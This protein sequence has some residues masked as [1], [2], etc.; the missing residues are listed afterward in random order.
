MKEVEI[1]AGHDPDKYTVERLKAKSHDGRLVPIS[2]IRLK[3]LN[4]MEKIKCC[5]MLM[6]LTNI[7]FLL[8]LVPQGF[9]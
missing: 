6:E 2:L 5:Y 4:K 8:R 3:N 9:V 7:V 1:P